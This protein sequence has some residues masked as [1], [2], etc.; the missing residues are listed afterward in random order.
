MENRCAQ[1]L[2]E[3]GKGVGMSKLKIA[4]MQWDAE[5]EEQAIELIERGVPPDEAMEKARVIVSNRWR[6]KFIKRNFV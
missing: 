5:V 6:E 1:Q 3:K 2:K 4:I